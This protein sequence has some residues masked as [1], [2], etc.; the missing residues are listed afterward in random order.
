MEI[1]N[2]I[3]LKLQGFSD[4]FLILAI[5]ILLE[6]ILPARRFS[7]K[8]TYIRL[9]QG[10]FY[11][12]V[13]LLL[14]WPIVDLFKEQI[15]ELRHLLPFS[16]H[17]FVIDFGSGAGL[18]EWFFVTVV[19]WVWW[20]FFQYW[21]HRLVHT[22]SFYFLHKHHHNVELDVFASFRH[23][24]LE[25]IFIHLTIAVPSALY[26]GVVYPD[27]GYDI[28]NLAIT[29]M[30]LIQHSNIRFGTKLGK[31]FITPQIHR[32]HHSQHPHHWN[33]NFS[34][35]FTLWDRVFKTYYFPPQR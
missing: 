25:L 31:F 8:Q 33:H 4:V 24:P 32:I 2:W 19:F 29:F 21:T 3:L 15:F 28:Q 26:F 17:K 14:V 5:I 11:L 23:S 12:F 20:D 10:I 18:L 30:V 35:Y 16:D 34:Q 27:L 22:K 13:S 6:V 9:T 1:I 7:A